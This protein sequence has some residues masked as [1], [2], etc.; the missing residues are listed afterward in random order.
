MS[1]KGVKKIAIAPGNVFYPKM[2]GGRVLVI[3]GA[4]KTSFFVSEWL[5]DTPEAD[6]KK[7]MWT[8]QDGNRTEIIAQYQGT[9]T[10]LN[11]FSISKRLS[12]AQVYY[13]EAAV[14]GQRDAVNL[15]GLKVRAWCK[16]Q[17]L[18]SAW[19]L[20]PNGAD[21]RK[22]KTIQYGEDVNVRFSTEG[23]NGHKLVVEVYSRKWFKDKMI[24]VYP[25]VDCVNGLASIKIP[26]TFSWFTKMNGDKSEHEFYIMVRIAGTKEYIT[27]SFNDDEHARFLKVEGVIY[28]KVVAKAQN[29]SL[30]V[31]VGESDF[32]IKRHEP[33][34]FTQLEITDDGKKFL[35]FDE[36]KLQ[37]KGVKKD[38]FSRSDMIYYDYDKSN[39]TS[40]A[41][42]V[43]DKLS[44]FLLESPYVPVELGSHTDIRGTAEYNLKLSRKRADAAVEYLVSKGISRSRIVSKGYGESMPL[45]SKANMTEEDHQQNRRTTILF[46]VFEN[47]AESIVYETV[48]GDVDLKKEMPLMIKAFTADGCL[49]TPLHNIKKVKV[50]ELTALTDDVNPKY[51][52]AV[53]GGQ[54]KP[55]V[56][57]ALT[58]LKVM[59]LNYMWPRMNA[60][61]KFLYYINTCRY[62]SNKER[63]SVAIV[64]YPD[65]KW[66]FHFS[67]N[68]SNSQ[69]VKWQ[70]LSPAKHKEMQ[71]KA[72]KL[73]AEARWK[74]VDVDFGVVLEANWNKSGDTYGGHAD[75]TLKYESKI[76]SVYSMFA[77]FKKFA[78][79]V[80]DTTKGKVSKTRLGKALPF[81]VELEAPNFCIGAE[82]QLE[83]GQNHRQKTNEIG[84]HVKFYFNS[85]PLL[86]VTLNI[87]LLA[88]IVTAA[89]T[90]TGNPQAGAIFNDIR[91]WLADEEHNITFK[92]YIDLVIKGTLK[93]AADIEINTAS[94]NN[95]LNAELATQLSAEVQAGL[96]IEGKAV[97]IGIEAFAKGQVKASGIASGKFG[98]HLKYDEQGLYY[99]PELLFEGLIVKFVIKADAGLSIKKGP[100]KGEKN[101]DLGSYETEKKLIPEFDII[102]NLEKYSG[103]SAN[104]PLIR[105]KE[106]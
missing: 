29:N 96:E 98:H 81:S 63:A 6:K 93:G 79:A 48:A 91:D 71:A 46:R 22:T 94:D 10:K 83:R 56:Y 101:I 87:D 88:A 62:F 31:K 89:G 59:P 90:A 25:D 97:F 13:L 60:A 69:S 106:I 86:L 35:L 5:P 54:I 99:R 92:L 34:S 45:I 21:I 27:D 68:L 75:V 26:N 53:Q 12:G 73:G 15:T 50:F 82:W 39:I 76:K 36:A 64:A 23:L 30:P 11:N 16:P 49:G 17:I 18:E 8:L 78:S 43:L 77:S 2:G 9:G 55:K 33:C 95:K 7:V 72:G 104:I 100:F 19:S 1:K 61:N 58:D 20:E 24:D 57:S 70:K 32:N 52:L 66:D 67:L 44:I 105:N 38:K 65:V 3:P 102:E 40:K 47:N 41:R 84:T 4:G 37:L 42:P 103:I 51:E 14:A 80:T 85:D 74:Q 28:N